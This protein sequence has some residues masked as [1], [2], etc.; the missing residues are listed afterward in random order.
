MKKL[1]TFALTLCFAVSVIGCGGKT[2]SKTDSA[3]TDYAKTESAKTESAKTEEAKTDA[4]T[5]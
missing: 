2:G 1:L 4:K 3:K 5:E